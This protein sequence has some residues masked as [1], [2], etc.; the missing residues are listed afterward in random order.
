[1]TEIARPDKETIIYDG[2]CSLCQRQVARIRRFDGRRVFD[3]VARQSPDLLARFPQLANEEFSTGMRLVHRD[4][5][6]AVGAD[7]VYEIARRLSLTRWVAWL[8]RVPGLHALAR[9]IYAHIAAN[10]YRIG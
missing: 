3:Y 7:A 9:R 4:G 6:V 5:R 10:R 2:I 1:M 8:Y